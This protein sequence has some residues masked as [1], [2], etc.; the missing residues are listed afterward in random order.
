M[1]ER[2]VYFKIRKNNLYIQ[3]D[4]YKIVEL[5]L[6]LE[7]SKITMKVEF[8]KNSHLVHIRNYDMGECGDVNVNDLIKQLH[9]EIYA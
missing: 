6:N 1:L 3:V 5:N 7:T 9:N 4:R 8:Y 2:E